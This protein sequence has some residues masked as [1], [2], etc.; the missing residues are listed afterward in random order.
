MQT[1]THTH[2]YRCHA[3]AINYSGYVKREKSL[4]YALPTAAR[5]CILKSVSFFCASNVQM[6]ISDSVGDC[7]FHFNDPTSDSHSARNMSSLILEIRV[8]PTKVNTNFSTFFL[9][10]TAKKKRINAP[11]HPI[12]IGRARLEVGSHRS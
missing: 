4:N 12:L 2:T 7:T 9:S 8:W 3:P 10:A 11:Q 6:V 1:P 5:I